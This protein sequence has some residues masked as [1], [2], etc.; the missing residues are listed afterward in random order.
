MIKVRNIMINIIIIDNTY[1]ELIFQFNIFTGISI[2]KEYIEDNG[3][4]DDDCFG[5]FGEE[6]DI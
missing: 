2:E 6:D 4:E 5:G 3:N 1:Y